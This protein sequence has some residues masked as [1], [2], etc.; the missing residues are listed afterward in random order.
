MYYAIWNYRWRQT[1]WFLISFG[2]V[3]LPW[4]PT[5]YFSIIIFICRF[6]P[7]VRY[8]AYT[9]KYILFCNAH[10]DDFFKLI[11]ITILNTL[12]CRLLV[13]LL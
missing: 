7:I 2:I 3:D 6:R 11:K 10:I 8:I 4:Q 13:F 1:V 12:V 5:I 9:L